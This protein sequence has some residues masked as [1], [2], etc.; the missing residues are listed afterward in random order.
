MRFDDGIVTQKTISLS[1]FFLSVT[2]SR[3]YS[4]AIVLQ[5][6]YSIIKMKPREKTKQQNSDYAKKFVSQT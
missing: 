4:S 1:D 3:H 5:Y 6:L 2:V